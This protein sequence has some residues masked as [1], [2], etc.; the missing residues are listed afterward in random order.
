[1]DTGSEEGSGAAGAAFLLFGFSC[2]VAGGAGEVCTAGAAAGFLPGFD[3]S[4]DT[5]RVS[6]LLLLCCLGV[7]ESATGASFLD[8]DCTAAIASTGGGGASSSKDVST[9]ARLDLWA[10]SRVEES[11]WLPRRFVP[12]LGS[13]G[14]EVSASAF[15]GNDAAFSA[16]LVDEAGS[17]LE[18]RVV[19]SLRFF[20]SVSKFCAASSASSLRAALAAVGAP[21]RSQTHSSNQVLLE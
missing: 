8:L 6:F 20:F 19:R 14:T 13:S 3:G 10:P 4:E 12:F 21:N 15:P 9:L 2:L 18:V 7:A 5:G 17:A 1:M 16:V 11:P